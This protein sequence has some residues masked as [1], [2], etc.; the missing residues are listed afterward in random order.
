MQA[1]DAVDTPQRRVI[2]G[3]VGG[4]NVVAMCGLRLSIVQVPAPIT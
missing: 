3:L 2:S 4:G 1:I